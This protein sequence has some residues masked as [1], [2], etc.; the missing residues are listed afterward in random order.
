MAYENIWLNQG[1]IVNYKGLL[2][3]DEVFKANNEITINPDFSLLKFIIFN[4][5]DSKL[6]NI[7]LVNLKEMLGMRLH[8]ATVNPDLRIA[9]VSTDEKIISELNK[10]LDQELTPFETKIFSTL[11]DAKKWMNR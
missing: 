6:K 7:K 5:L 3:A 9:Y 11:N 8:A 2:S 4:Y 10:M 1:V